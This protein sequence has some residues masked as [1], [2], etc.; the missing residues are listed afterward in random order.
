[1]T[2]DQKTQM[3]YYRKKGHGYKQIAKLTGIS[4]NTVKSYFRRNAL[5]ENESVCEQCGREIVQQKGR[6]RKRFCSDSCRNKWWN[7]HLDLVKRKA[8]YE[9]LCAFCKKPFTAYGN[10]KRKYCCFE[11]YSNSRIKN[12][13]FNK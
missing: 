5:N 2:N 6:K 7:S 1:M 10:A 9:Y 4:V 12:H 8:N 13:N 11:C 3:E